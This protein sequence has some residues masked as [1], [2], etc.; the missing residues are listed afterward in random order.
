MSDHYI[1]KGREIVKADLLTWGKWL[2]ENR[3]ARIVKQE[4]VGAYW[5]STV[6][7]GLNHQYGE[8]PPLLFET[9]VFEKGESSDLWCDRCSTYDEAEAMHERGCEHVRTSLMN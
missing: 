9:M 4:D 6:F 2:E 5:V 7:L 1:L 8:G 3:E